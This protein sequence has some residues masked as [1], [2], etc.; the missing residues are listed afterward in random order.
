MHPRAGC[1]MMHF[2]MRAML[3]LSAVFLVAAL[4]PP[5]P[6]RADEGD[7]TQGFVPPAEEERPIAQTVDLGIGRTVGIATGATGIAAGLAVSVVGIY[8]IAGSA[9]QGFDSPRLQSGII[10]TGT[11]VIFSSL[12]TLLTEWFLDSPPPDRRGERE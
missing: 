7:S 10:L 2:A 12:S 9:D 5:L 4:L 3:R 11:G 6:C 1:D 8:R